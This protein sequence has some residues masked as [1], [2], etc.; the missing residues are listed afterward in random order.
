VSGYIAR[1]LA[2]HEW[3]ESLQALVREM[4]AE[5]GKTDVKGRGMGKTR[6]R[7]AQARVT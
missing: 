3:H 2:E 5:D 7:T 6:V 4:I 1:V